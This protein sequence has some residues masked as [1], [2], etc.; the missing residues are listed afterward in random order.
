MPTYKAFSFDPIYTTPHEL[1]TTTNSLQGL[2]S[3]RIY[4]ISHEIKTSP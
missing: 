4:I 3:I 2:P 1:P